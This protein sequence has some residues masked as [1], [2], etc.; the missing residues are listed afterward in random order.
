MR[1]FALI[2]MAI[3]ILFVTMGCTKIPAGNIGIKV[4][5]YGD[6]KGVNASTVQPGRYF[7]TFGVDYYKYPLFVNMYPFTAGIDE[8]SPIDESFNFQT[9]EGVKCNADIGVQARADGSKAT[10]LFQTYREDMQVIIKQYVKADIRDAMNRHVAS[11]SV[12]SLYGSGKIT[13][14]NNVTKDLQ[15]KYSKV[16]LIIESVTLLSDIRFPKEI[17][18][19]IV[20]K[21]TA[22]QKAMQR[23]NEL[24]EAEALAK[25]KVIEAEADAAAN[26]AKVQTITPQLIEWERLQVTKQFIDAWKEGKGQVPQTLVTGQSKFDLLFNAT[27]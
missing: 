11:L 27:K 12:D 21:M 17:Q 24:R 26:R 5:L 6:N 20:D 8:G 1:K 23:E 25:K 19:G 10:T 7:E 16:G 22:S 13:L 9:K 4:N 15:D 18:Q 2:V 14:M 3:I